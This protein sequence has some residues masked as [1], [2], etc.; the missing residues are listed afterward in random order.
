MIPADNTPK[1][2]PAPL[3]SCFPCPFGDDVWTPE[4]LHWSSKAE[5]WVC[6]QCWKV[7]KHGERGARLDRY[8]KEVK[9]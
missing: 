5:T 9:P 4:E 8:L 2:T 3:Y 6:N 1:Y 7:E